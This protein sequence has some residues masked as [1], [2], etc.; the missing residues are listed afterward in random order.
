MKDIK[1][2]S[3]F[4]LLYD[5]IH[6]E[7]HNSHIIKC[8]ASFHY[9]FADSKFISFAVSFSLSLSFFSRS[10]RIYDR[11]NAISTIYLCRKK[12]R[13]HWEEKRRRMKRNTSE[14]TCN[15]KCGKQFLPQN[16]QNILLL[17]FDI[18]YL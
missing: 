6:A 1:L 11:M 4:F 13:M 9:S 17:V 3:L 8:D 18:I 2:L 14:L 7:K 10:Y 16:R 5:I 12:K 15:L